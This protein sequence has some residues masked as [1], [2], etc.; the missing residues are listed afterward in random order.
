MVRRSAAFVFACLLTAMQDGYAQQSGPARP[1]GT[2]ESTAFY[3]SVRTYVNPV[4]PGDHPDP[5]LLKVGN[6]FYHCGSSFHFN[7]YLPVYHSKDLVHWKVIGRVLPPSSAGM[8]SDRPGGGVW[9]GA[10]TYFYGSYWIYFSAGG[11]WFSK[12]SSPEGPWS[13][14]VRVKE[15]PVTGPLGYDNSIFVDDGK[16]YMVIKNGQKVNRLQA[17]GP[18]GQLTDSVINLDWINARLQ[19]S[20][21]EGP[22]MCKRNGYY[23]YF[24][25]GDVSGG[26]Y[27]LRT[28]AL[29]A[30]S[31]KWERL[32]DF[33]KPI[34]DTA[35]AFPRPNHISA[36]VQLEDG[37]WWTIGQSY[38]KK[39]NDDWSGMGRQTSLYQ[40]IWEGDRPWG[41]APS[42]GP[43]VKPALENDNTPWR[44]VRSDR[45]GSDS[46]G[47]WWHFLSKPAAA[48]YS[49][50]QRKG[51]L[52]LLPDSGRTHLLQK[53]TDHY[54]AAVTRLQV[55]DDSGALGG[56]YLTNGKQSVVARLY[57]A[58]GNNPRIVFQL[59]TALR[60]MPYRAGKDVWLKLERFEH[61]L[62]GFYSADGKNWQDIGPFISAKP[63]DKAQPDFNSWVGTSIGLFAEKGPVDFHSFTGKDG[64]SPL[65][66]I[67]ASNYYG[68]SKVKGEE[69]ASSSVHGGWIMISGV[70]F[71]AGGEAKAVEITGRAG[72]GGK[73][74]LWIDDLEKG[75]KIAEVPVK[76]KGSFKNMLSRSVSGQ[77]DLF[78]RFPR[79]A[80]GDIHIRDIRLSGKEK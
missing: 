61:N 5:T 71:G 9:Q 53:E 52:R 27:V 8:V 13:A 1:P 10:I 79:G 78:V 67:G 34:T 50:T 24:P 7:P 66:A 58:S 35:N 63:I 17:L 26:Q 30:D 70:D 57:Y 51:W 2:K 48:K 20:W 12:A 22:V 46:L 75:V 33:F 49:L 15:N 44:S 31:S 32:G 28:T 45:F 11:Q 60:E 40:V 16:P 42:S 39:G 59:D 29:T 62:K 41:V 55:N 14:P 72:K 77:H 74:E 54:Y 23:Y 6:D 25:A 56:I 65:P 68:I 36:P 38:E 69:V 80:P 47:A 19:Y 3:S 18:D 43:V 73:L 76:G 37:T 64:F 4:L 21:A